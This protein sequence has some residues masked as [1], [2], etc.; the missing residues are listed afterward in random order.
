MGKTSYSVELSYEQRI[1]GYS[2]LMLFVGIIMEFFV[3]YLGL[4]IQA[5]LQTNPRDSVLSAIPKALMAAIKNPL[6]FLP[7]NYSTFP[8]I[9]CVVVSV[10]LLAI[11]YA[12]EVKKIHHNINT[13]KGS[14]EWQSALEFTQRF[15][16]YE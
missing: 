12:I 2:K 9:V 6:Y 3:V 14:A 1:K 7:I 4:T 13:I 15:A 8:V 11:M 10:L 16:E 5:Y